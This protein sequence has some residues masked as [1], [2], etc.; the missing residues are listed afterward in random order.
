MPTRAEIRDRMVKAGV[1]ICGMVDFC[2]LRDKL[3]PCSALRRLPVNAKTVIMALFPYYLP[4]E[5]DRRISRYAVPRDYHLTVGESLTAASKKLKEDFPDNEFVPFCDASPIPEV[6]AARL[7]GLGAAGR[8]G[9]LINREFGSFVFIGEIVTDLEV[10]GEMEKAGE[11]CL[12]CG[13]CVRSC[14][15]GA[16]GANGIDRERCVSHLTQK[17]GV[18]TGE[19]ERLI[20]KSGSLW[21]CDIC[22]DVCPMNRKIRETGLKPF[23]DDLKMT[24]TPDELE[25]ED[26]AVRMKDRAFLWRGI[27]VLKRNLRILKG[28]PADNKDKSS[29]KEC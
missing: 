24:I 18:L 8:H 25:Q 5:G 12:S 27:G 15:G 6:Y 29:V 10:S 20:Q 11:D 28:A 22:Q 2:C 14:P 7:A 9:L 19:Q 3:I 1:K 4:L 21:G 17:K 26:F 13:L 16:I 23:R